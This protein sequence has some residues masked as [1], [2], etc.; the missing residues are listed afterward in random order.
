MKKK[1]LFI[2]I[3]IALFSHF[4]A[5]FAQDCDI[6][7]E[8]AINL[9]NDAKNAAIRGNLAEAKTYLSSAVILLRPCPSSTICLSSE[10]SVLLRDAQTI[11]NTTAL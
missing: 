6:L 9:V 7:V 2:I 5:V 11:T 8:N 4:N 1:H 3:L 10:V